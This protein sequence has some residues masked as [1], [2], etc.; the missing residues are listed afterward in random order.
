MTKDDKEWLSD[1]ADLAC[2]VC[3]NLGFGE[4]PAEIHHIRTSQGAGQ[5][6]DHKK[7]LPLCPA[8]H[9]TGGYGVAIHAGQKH[10]EQLYGTELQL[11]DQV[12]TEVKVLR[13]CRI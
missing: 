8:H 3:R 9:R 5:R 4:T 12:V 6:A 1:V 10:W 11:L 13:L 7:T 2:V